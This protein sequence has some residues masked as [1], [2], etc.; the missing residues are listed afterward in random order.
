[1]T[2]D[3]ATFFHIGMGIVFIGAVVVLYCTARQ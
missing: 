2:F 3:L 1:M